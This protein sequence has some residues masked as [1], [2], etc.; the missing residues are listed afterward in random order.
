MK[1][2]PK[3]QCVNK[4]NWILGKISAVDKFLAT[5]IKRNSNEKPIKLEI[6]DA[7]DATRR[8]L[9]NTCHKL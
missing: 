9:Q 5:L 3:K 8:L 1:F 7:K 4:K 6:K 2:Q